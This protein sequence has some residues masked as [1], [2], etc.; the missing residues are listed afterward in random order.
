MANNGSRES[1]AVGKLPYEGN[2]HEMVFM[3]SI[4]DLNRLSLC[5]TLK[6]DEER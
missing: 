1:I 4:A 2:S 5:F 6:I 3:N